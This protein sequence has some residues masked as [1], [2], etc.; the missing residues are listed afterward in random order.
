MTFF[1][2]EPNRGFVGKGY[3]RPNGR[4][5]VNLILDPDVIEEL[6]AFALRDRISLSEAIRLMIEWGLES[7]ENGT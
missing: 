4:I 3:T 5:Q 2:G 7:V 1:E 6:R